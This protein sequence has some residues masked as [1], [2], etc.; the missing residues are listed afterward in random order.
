M[1]SRATSFGRQRITFILIGCALASGGPLV[2]AVPRPPTEGAI[3]D[4]TASFATKSGELK[5]D[6]GAL[7][8]TAWVELA[9]TNGAQVFLNAGE[10]DT[11]FTFYLYNGRVRMLVDHQAGG[12]VYASAPPPA[13]K[14]WVHYAGTYDGQTVRIYLNGEE[15]DAKEAPGGLATLPTQLVI[16]GLNP[17]ER[18]L[19]GRLAGLRVWR[20]ALTADEVMAVVSGETG[21][22]LTDGLIAAYDPAGLAG[23]VWKSALA[24]APDAHRNEPIDPKAGVLINAKDDGYRGIWYYNQPSNDEYVYKYSG[25]YGTY[26]ANHIPHSWHVPK[27]NKTFFT[28]GGT[29]HDSFT[30]LIHMVSYYDHSTG[31]VPRPTVLL[32][33]KTSDAHDNP[34]INV[35]DQ[36]YIWIFS[37][38]HGRGRPSYISKSRQPYSVDAFDLVWVGNFSY[39]QPWHFPGHGFVF[40]HTFYNPGRSIC[41]MTSPDGVTWT[42]RREL[43]YIAEGHYQV[44]WPLGSGKIGSSFMYHPLGK[45]LNWRTN[46]YYMES[47]DF[48]RTWKTVDGK[49]LE[50]PL[51]DINGPALVREYE[52][53]GLLVYIVDL[54]CDSRGNPII[55]YITSKGYES[56]PKNMPRTWTTAYWNGSEWE[57]HGGDIVSDSN[58]DHG[59]LYVERDDLW[60]VIGP[61]LDGPQVFNP[62]GEVAMWESTDHGKSWKLTRKLTGG[63]ELN[64]TYV[65][66]P[67]NA[68]A[69]FYG[70]WADG[71][72]RKPSESRL[73]FCNQ[74]G[75]VFRLPP[76]MSA[77]FQKPELV[78]GPK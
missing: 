61:T 16:G 73:Y 21:S 59:S 22:R 15:Q 58:Y 17:T 48:G 25:G 28:Y 63:S 33:K 50:L 7:S 36:G 19:R 34:V 68:H 78:S 77:D 45:G 76:K 40:M 38:S 72:G 1:H 44:S 55:L 70:F 5:L 26:C 42:D 12:Y 18:I 10:S 24:S 37:S 64:H 53:K 47:T 52:S 74:K 13:A 43:S 62:G 4:G 35:D 69:D 9:D 49:P 14:T 57:I 46:L 71:H 20:R 51:K 65:R 56:G 3:L 39:P 23:E 30:R 66:R 32:D 54:N 60:R 2:L 41:M 75:D 6:A 29:T 8:V 31:M 67:V 11:G 27:V